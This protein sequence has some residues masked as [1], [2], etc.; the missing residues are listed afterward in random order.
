MR[1]LRLPT[2]R[3]TASV[4]FEKSPT[5]GRLTLAGIPTEPAGIQSVLA[6]IEDLANVTIRAAMPI[7][8]VHMTRVDAEEKY[9]ADI[10]DQFPIPDE[11]TEV[12]VLTVDDATAHRAED[13]APGYWN[14]NCCPKPHLETTAG[15]GELRISKHNY[16]GSKK[17]LRLHFEVLPA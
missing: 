5:K 14:V 3:T 17:E 7:T 8:Q 13:T 11:V 9:G 2:A 12:T 10:Y 4:K 1:V 6:E 16:N 15:L